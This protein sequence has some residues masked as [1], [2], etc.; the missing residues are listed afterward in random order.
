MEDSARQSIR[1]KVAARYSQVASSA[2][3]QF[4]YPVGPESLRR[5]NYPSE[6]LRE[7]PEEAQRHFCGLGNPFS[8]GEL[9]RGESVLDVG[10]GAGFDCLVAASLV[11]PGGSVVGIDPT[12]AMVERA[13]TN[14]AATS[15][16]NVRFLAARG[17]EIPLPD[18]TVDA[19]IS[20]AAINLSPD[21]EQ[22]L[23]EIHRVMRPGGRLMLADVFLDEGV[24]PET[25]AALDAW[26]A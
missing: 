15:F 16:A 26:S 24:S 17:E 21:K 6:I 22:V 19:V 3:N 12:E 20:N 8:L 18:S 9:H 1:A 23:A 11:G 10:C 4:K 7:L 5:L 2:A 13:R 14:L 25:V